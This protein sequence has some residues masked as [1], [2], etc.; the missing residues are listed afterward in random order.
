MCSNRFICISLLRVI[1]VFVASSY[2]VALHAEPVAL[3]PDSNHQEH[4]YVD[5][6]TFVL[7]S[8]SASHIIW[9][10]RSDQEL[11][12]SAI[13]MS[14]HGLRVRGTG[15]N[16]SSE[17][18]QNFVE[19]K[20]WL[21]DHDRGIAH[22][23]SMLEMPELGRSSP[24]SAASFLGPN[25]CG[26]LDAVNKGPGVWRGRRVTAFY[27]VDKTDEVVA[28]EFLDDIYEVVVYASTPDGVASEVRGLSEREFPQSHYYPPDDYRSV[29]KEEFFFGSPALKPYSQAQD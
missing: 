27:C 22:E 2:S 13:E 12:S 7:P 28:I 20:A 6:D 29:E 17:M 8:F 18:L 5:P 9:H 23:L 25:P 24:G 3:E 19:E 26:V 10:E 11:M 21:I 14:P 16:D 1:G 4:E 15:P